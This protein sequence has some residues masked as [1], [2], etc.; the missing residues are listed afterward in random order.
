M[1]GSAPSEL[2]DGW[3]DAV[4]GRIS[5]TGNN[6][7]REVLRQ[8]ADQT[9]WSGDAE[10]NEQLVSTLRS[11]SSDHADAIAHCQSTATRELAL[12]QALVAARAHFLTQVAS[13]DSSS[14][15]SL[16]PKC[17]CMVGS[18]HGDGIVG[19]MASGI[20]EKRSAEWPMLP[21]FVHATAEKFIERID[22]STAMALVSPIDRSG[23]GEPLS[24]DWWQRC[25]QR[26]DQTGTLLVVDHSQLPPVG[27]GYL[28]AHE[29]VGGVSA[30]A[31]I[32]SSGLVGDLPGG[33]LVASNTIRDQLRAL[34]KSSSHA[35][36]DLVGRL[37]LKSLLTLQEANALAIDANE[38]AVTLAE[39]IATRGCVR[40]MHTCGRTVIL[41]LDVESDAWTHHASQHRLHAT[42]ASEH[43]VLFQPPLL[44][45]DED[46]E[47]LIDR[48][49]RV[50]AD[51]EGGSDEH[52]ASET[53]STGTNDAG[54]AILSNDAHEVEEHESA[55]PADDAWED[56]HSAWDDA[57]APESN[58]SD[59]DPASDEDEDYEEE[60]DDEEDALEADEELEDEDE[61]NGESDDEREI[62]GEAEPN[63]TPQSQA[64]PQPTE[65][66][67]TELEQ[68]ELDEFETNEETEKF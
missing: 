47:A 37:V 19:R 51:L 52:I 48:I 31:V 15:G 13:A 46:Q 3:I 16:S 21:G 61:L 43:S 9:S 45:S 39:R 68:V 64:A 8:F 36:H 23:I 55:G 35:S 2:D 50:L 49:D 30:D 60:T 44:I 20:T 18:D 5:A 59:D 12:E 24:A 38:F 53:E 41:E 10:L 32:L 62:V 17:V 28:F 65:T 33:L 42:I 26:C 63:E 57:D 66:E 40:D 22:E 6:I 14:D 67:Q 29:L 56:N 25:R 7:Y 54:D 1:S 4:S 58:E 27:N 11:L 34:G